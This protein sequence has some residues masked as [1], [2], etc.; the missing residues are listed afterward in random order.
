VSGVTHTITGSVQDGKVQGKDA[1][2]EQKH[3]LKARYTEV[4]APHQRRTC[5]HRTQA[6]AL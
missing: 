6:A 1:D 5:R 2:D 3:P 4:R